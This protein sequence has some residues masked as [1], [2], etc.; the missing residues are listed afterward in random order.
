MALAAV[1]CN[2]EVDSAKKPLPVCDADDPTCPGVPASSSP[3][4]PH[5]EMPTDP[6][7]APATEPTKVEPATGTGSPDASVDSAPVVGKECAKLSTC[8]DQLGKA[9]Y[10]TT[11]CKS[12]LSTNNEDAC[13]T[14]HASYKSAGDCT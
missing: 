4:K 6:V 14:Q 8:C 5:T 10:I 3:K 11:T 2:A 1:A 9:G 7:P 13:Y 12:V